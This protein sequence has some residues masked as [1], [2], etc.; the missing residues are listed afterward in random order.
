M[1]FVSHGAIRAAFCS[2]VHLVVGSDSCVEDASAA[3]TGRF[4]VPFYQSKPY[5]SEIYS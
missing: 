4:F 2:G 3:I 1:D 5:E